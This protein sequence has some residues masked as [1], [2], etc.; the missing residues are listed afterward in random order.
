MITLYSNIKVLFIPCQF[1]FYKIWYLSTIIRQK[2]VHFRQN[3]VKRSKLF[4]L[5]LI[6]IQ[7][8]DYK[9]ACRVSQLIPSF[10]QYIKSGN[11]P[12]YI[13]AKKRLVELIQ[14]IYALCIYFFRQSSFLLCT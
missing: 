1:Y 4:V 2:Y 13:R 12:T 6:N 9:S 5:K 14:T 11:T 3:A 8:C 7:H 10:T